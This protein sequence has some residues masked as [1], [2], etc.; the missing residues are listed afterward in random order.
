MPIDDQGHGLPWQWGYDY[1]RGEGEG[2]G[3]SVT[4]RNASCA[5]RRQ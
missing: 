1:I 4:A 3:I 2:I 5:N